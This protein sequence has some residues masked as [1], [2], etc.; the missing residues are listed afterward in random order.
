MSAPCSSN[1]RVDRRLDLLRMPHPGLGPDR[2]DP[3]GK[4]RDEPQ[5]LARMLFT[6][7]TGRDHP[8][9][10]QGEREPKDC[11]GQEYAFR[12]MTKRTMAKICGN[13]LARIKPAVKGHVVIDLAALEAAI[14]EEGQGDAT[15]AV[16]TA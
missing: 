1:E 16:A 8:T 11:L 12:M 6:D 13:L 5:I 4:A 2:L 10:G 14:A 7:P 15:R 9:S 3:I